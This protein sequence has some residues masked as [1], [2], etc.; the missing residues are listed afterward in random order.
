MR[1]Y[2]ASQSDCEVL[3]VSEDPFKEI[4]EKANIKLSEHT[5]ELMDLNHGSIQGIRNAV[6]MLRDFANRYEAIIDRLMLVLSI[7]A[8]DIADLYGDQILAEN[9]V[10]ADIF[11]EQEEVEEEDT[12]DES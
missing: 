7:A 3:K 10:P 12:D 2:E 6:F 1:R 9:G 11:E 4:L 8:K 5:D